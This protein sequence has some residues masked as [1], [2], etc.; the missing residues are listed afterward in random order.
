M[1]T[2]IR[3]KNFTNNL[4]RKKL[5]FHEKVVRSGFIYKKR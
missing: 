1:F 2:P 3:H 4:P 5:K